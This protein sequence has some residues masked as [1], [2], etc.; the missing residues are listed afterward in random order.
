MKNGLFIL[1]FCLL[2]G[3]MAFAQEDFHY[4]CETGQEMA[5]RIVSSVPPELMLMKCY[6]HFGGVTIPDT[7]EY[8]ETKYAVVAIYTSA[9]SPGWGFTGP[10]VIPN[11]VREIGYGAF[12]DC[13]FTGPL[14]IPNS[15]E[16]I[17]T[18]A[19]RGCEKFSSLKLSQSLTTIREH[20]FADCYGFRGDLVI[21]ESVEDVEP[22]AF[23]NCGFDGTLYISPRMAICYDDAF[24]DCYNFSAV[25]IPEGV[26]YIE[27]FAFSNL[28]KPTELELPS[29]VTNILDEAFGNMNRLEQMIVNA[30]VPPHIHSTS[31]MQTSRDIPV[32]IPVGT[33]EAYEKASNWSEFTN[34]IE[35]E[36]VGIVER[37]DA[38]TATVYP[39]PGINT[40]NI[41]INSPNAQVEVYD[42]AGQLIHSQTVAEGTVAIDATLWPSGVYVWCLVSE[43]K[44][45]TTGKW[46]KK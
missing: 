34:F 41:Q 38:A 44:E 13:W 3:T 5:F 43:K 30:S 4:V 19:F 7:V 15:V 16:S 37:D 39:N 2:I 26:I 1:T 23:E 29:T 24:V 28:V 42:M 18:W 11:T 27:Y 10:L 6:D 8:N 31:F 36:G 12:W 25:D 9:F 14:V 40:L 22:F 20:T 46:I 32:Y 17:D 35:L 21:P 45:K 33:K